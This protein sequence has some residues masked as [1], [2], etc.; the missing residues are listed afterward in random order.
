VERVLEEEQ[1][2]EMKDSNENKNLIGKVGN[3]LE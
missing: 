3:W 1:K 2:F